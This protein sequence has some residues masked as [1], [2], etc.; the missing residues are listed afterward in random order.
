M[1]NL[2]ERF[3]EEAF[4]LIEE[5]EKISLNLKAENQDPT[6]V[7][8]IFRIMHSLKGSGGMFGFENISE[9]TH[10]LESLFDL[11]RAGKLSISD[12]IILLTL[13]AIDHLK[14][15]VDHA[16]QKDDQFKSDHENLKAK[17]KAFYNQ[18]TFS[19]NQNQSVDLIQ[20]MSNLY[21]KNGFDI[22]FIPFEN[23]FDNGSNPLFLIDKLVDLGEA[24]IQVITEKIDALED[25]DVFKCRTSWK[26]KLTTFSDQNDI[27]DVFIFVDDSCELKIR[28]L[29][30]VQS[31]EI[32]NNGKD[33]MDL[34]N[35]TVFKK[36]NL[37]EPEI[38]NHP[39]EEKLISSIRVSS[40][41]LDILM[42]LVS[43]LVTTQ[44]R[45]GLVANNSKNDE[46]NS[47]SE[48]INKLS[49][50]LRDIT[51]EICLV[52]I[53][54]VMTRFRRLVHDLSAELNKNIEFITEGTETEID[55]T[56]VE[57]IV[58]P[59]MH[60]I[61]NSIDHGIESPE[62]RRKL[63]KT[64]QGNIHLKAYHSGANV[65]IEVK[66]DGKGIDSQIIR[67]KAIDKKLIS[68]EAVYTEKELL[69][70]IFLP[71]LS[72]AQKVT[73]ISGRGVGMDVV[74]KKISSVRGEV[75]ILSKIGTGTTIVLKLPLTLSIIDGLLIQVGETFFLIP[76]GAVEKIFET[77]YDQIQKAYN[78]LIVLGS[79]Q[80][81][82]LSLREEFKISTPFDNVAEIVVVR[83][84]EQLMGLV[85]D[86][87]MGEHQ[88]VLKPL[89]RYYRNHEFFSGASILGDGTVALVM[90][91]N[92][93]ILSHTEN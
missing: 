27:A 45:L 14:M 74:M 39:Q 80:Y 33:V 34:S 29:N 75:E 19:E 10:E 50:Q 35:Q 85:V 41:K 92:K 71:G 82:F 7:E 68:P 81:P 61:R 17:I 51:F 64:P 52:P 28:S 89:G 15:L 20:K 67:N 78:N 76:L 24:H 13:Q 2:Q 43:E 86:R 53:E 12:E 83:Y 21:K 8:R 84:N 87:V 40:Q 70:M 54:S 73:G 93:L 23:I 48:D 18:I 4:D 49:K 55:K 5:L 25:L 9:F 32:Q 46:L 31:D 88:A 90:D 66:D 3:R 6:V 91:T 16:E 65:I 69:N 47:I 26:V 44:A 30:K 62:E 58:D 42:N 38:S 37:I 1:E 60:L 22:E 72:T 36:K 56:I 59:I 77:R 79:V 11:I 63:G 57:I